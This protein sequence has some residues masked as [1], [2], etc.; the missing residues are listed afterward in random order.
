M[1]EMKI[2]KKFRGVKKISND[3]MGTI[4]LKPA[5]ARAPS[6]ARSWGLKSRTGWECPLYLQLKLEAND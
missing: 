1:P 2:Q 3:E 4:G 6:E 5:T